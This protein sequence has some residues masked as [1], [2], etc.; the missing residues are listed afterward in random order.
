MVVV[1]VAGNGGEVVVVQV[2]AEAVAGPRHCSGS[3]VCSATGIWRGGICYS[4]QAYRN[5]QERRRYTYSAASIWYI[6]MRSI[7]AAVVL[8]TRYIRQARQA[9][10][11]V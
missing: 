2:V 11:A 9:A 7:C 1:Q 8:C 5:Q 3:G 4:R 6:H 10:Q